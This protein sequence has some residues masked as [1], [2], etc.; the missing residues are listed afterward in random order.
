MTNCPI[1]VLMLEGEIAG[2]HLLL[3]ICD[4]CAAGRSFGTGRLESLGGPAQ[5]QDPLGKGRL[6]AVCDCQQPATPHRGPKS[7]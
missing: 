7:N 6:S 1:L 3:S 5:A 2:A 4:G